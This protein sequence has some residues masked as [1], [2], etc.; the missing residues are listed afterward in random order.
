MR[1]PHCFPI[2]IPAK[3]PF[4]GP[5][6]VRCLN[7]VRSMISPRI[8]CR[9]GYA[10]QMNEIT[11]FIDASHVYGPTPA[12]ASNLRQFARGLLKV[13]IIEGR[14]YLPEDPLDKSCV[15]RKPGFGCFLSGIS[16][17]CL[18]SILF[19]DIGTFFSFAFPQVIP[20]LIKL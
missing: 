9:M 15:G 16:C 4:Y 18:L 10:E 6:G 17:T 11:H 12:T 19:L 14:P 3:D 2:D 1:H 20:E 13:S 5:R 8:E 7:F